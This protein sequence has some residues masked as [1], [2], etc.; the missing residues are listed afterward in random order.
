MSAGGLTLFAALAAGLAGGAHC[1]AMCGPLVAATGAGL[2]HGAPDTLAGALKFNLGRLL[3]YG[4]AGA[5]TAGLLGG[6]AG[7]SPLPAI[8]LALRILAGIGLAAVGLRLLGVGDL[9]RIERLGY[10]LWSAIRPAMRTGLRLPMPI[11]PIA[12]GLLWGF[13]PCGLVYSALLMAAATGDAATGAWTMIIFGIGTLPVL[14]G[15]TLGGAT[16]GTYLARPSMRRLTGTL[17]LA[18][19]GWTVAVA[20]LH[21]AGA[22]HHHRHTTDGAAAHIVRENGPLIASRNTNP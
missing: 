16:L 6:I 14:L 15:I 20:L 17:A 11:R 1:A 2:R 3:G 12:L 7:A 21:P 22:A 13:M 19:A 8:A 18:A 4:T 9:L 5:V 10:A